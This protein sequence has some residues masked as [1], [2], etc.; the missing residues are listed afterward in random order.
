M[1]GGVEGLYFGG[2]GGGQTEDAFSK[3]YSKSTD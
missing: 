3:I 2:R 1:D